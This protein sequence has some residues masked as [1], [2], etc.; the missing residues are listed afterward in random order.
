M[1][2]AFL[3]KVRLNQDKLIFCLKVIKKNRGANML[4]PPVLNRVKILCKKH[5][6]FVQKLMQ[7]DHFF[8]NLA[9]VFSNQKLYTIR[10]MQPNCL[11]DLSSPS[12]PGLLSQ[13]LGG[14]KRK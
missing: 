11:E 10:G 2:N 5:P 3:G 9:Q 14:R 13:T 12:I 6:I 1:R 7:S 4:P 8:V